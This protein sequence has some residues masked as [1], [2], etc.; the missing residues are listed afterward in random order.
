[1]STITVE[2]STT[3][4]DEYADPRPGRWAH[5]LDLVAAKYAPS[6][7]TEPIA[8]GRAQVIEKGEIFQRRDDI[9]DITEADRV[10]VNGVTYDIN[11]RPRAWTK[12]GTF[13][14]IVIAVIR[15]E[16]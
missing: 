9:P 10:T 3:V 11:G 14:G 7:P 16:G 1:M 6:N 12:N 13:V 5:H 2:R 15:T 8:L 4:H